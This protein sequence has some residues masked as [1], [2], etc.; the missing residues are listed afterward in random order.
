MKIYIACRYSRRS[1]AEALAQRLESKGHVVTSRW[2]RSRDHELIDGLPPRATDS[3]RERFAR[4]DISDIGKAD[5]LVSLMEPD[6][7]NNS[8]GGRHVEFG[9]ALGIGL[10]CIVIGNRETVFHHL[11]PV[12]HYDNVAAF[13][14]ALAARQ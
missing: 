7:R 6:S 12:E 2:H 1:E 9:Y 4:E 8:R 5:C 14:A 11:L 13:E 3:E 10:Y